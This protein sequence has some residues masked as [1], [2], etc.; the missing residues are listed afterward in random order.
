MIDGD[1]E[2]IETDDGQQRL[3]DQNG[4]QIIV[5]RV[6]TTTSRR[7]YHRVDLDAYQNDEIRPACGCALSDDSRWWLRRRAD[8]DAVWTE[9]SYRTCF[10]EYDQSTASQRENGTSLAHTLSE[11]S[12]EEF[13]AQ[14]C[15][16]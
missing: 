4:D 8:L 14:R 11:M 5:R 12:V 1:P 16:P 15:Q 7:I 6:N 13:D 9:C 10:G 2:I 3:V